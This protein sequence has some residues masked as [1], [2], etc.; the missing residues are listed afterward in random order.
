MATFGKMLPRSLLRVM[1]R[2]V[3]ALNIVSI[4]QECVVSHTID[5]APDRVVCLLGRH[6]CT[7]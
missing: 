3:G 5:S 6:E 2:N 1:Q 7:S 4:S